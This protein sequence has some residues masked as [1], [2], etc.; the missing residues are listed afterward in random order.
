MLFRRSGG[1][2]TFANVAKPWGHSLRAKECPQTPEESPEGG[3]RFPP[4]GSP[5]NDQR[6]GAVAPTLWKP[7]RGCS[8]ERKKTPRPYFVTAE[9]FVCLQRFHWFW[10]PRRHLKAH[11]VWADQRLALP[12]KRYLQRLASE[13]G[14]LVPQHKNPWGPGAAA[15][16]IF[17]GGLGTIFSMWKRWSPES[18][19]PLWENVFRHVGGN[20]TKT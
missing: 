2:V 13:F 7:T 10:R 9:G 14:G 18:G 1:T 15:P 4:S 3:F 19:F 6:A 20:L 5:L 12:I 17:S 8:I 11:K 16:G